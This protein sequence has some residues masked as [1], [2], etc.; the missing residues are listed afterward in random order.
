MKEK[1]MKQFPDRYYIDDLHEWN[2]VSR[3]DVDLR[4][5]D[6]IE[7]MEAMF[8]DWVREESWLFPFPAILFAWIDA[9]FTRG[10][11][12]LSRTEWLLPQSFKAARD[13]ERCSWIG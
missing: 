7:E 8:F 6:E 10:T 9:L 5:I 13:N 1:L 12:R 2:S 3:K 11:I 4:W